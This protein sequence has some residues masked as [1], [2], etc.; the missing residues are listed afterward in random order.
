MFVTVAMAMTVAM[1]MVVIV[2]P[3]KVI[4]SIS[5]VQN[6]HLNQIEEESTDGS[7]HHDES[8]DLLRL[9]DSFSCFNKQSNS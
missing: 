1:F 4:M 2:T 3:T 7:D 8:I 9:P 5:L 6:V